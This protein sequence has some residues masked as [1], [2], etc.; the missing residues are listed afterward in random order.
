[1]EVLEKYLKLFIRLEKNAFKM[2][3]DTSEVKDKIIYLNTIEQLFERGIDSDGDSLR[4]D[5]SPNTVIFKQEKGQ[6][7]DH[8]TL[9]DTGVFYDSF[10][11]TVGKDFFLID[12][13][14]QKDETNLLDIYGQDVLG[15]TEQSK[16]EIISLAYEVLADLIYDLK[17]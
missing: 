8:V 4:P 13:D 10:V 2:V 9:N 3:F 11:V 12:A 7:Y 16:E 1:M 14:P 15:L 5:Y 6:R 17:I